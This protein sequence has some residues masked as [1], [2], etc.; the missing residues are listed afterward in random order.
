M[1]EAFFITLLPLFIAIMALVVVMGIIWFFIRVSAGRNSRSAAIMNSRRRMKSACRYVFTSLL[2]LTLACLA[3]LLGVYTSVYYFVSPSLAICG[4][5]AF[6]LGII[7]IVKT[8]GIDRGAA[9]VTLII[10]LS[11]SAILG[12]IV[13]SVGTFF[14]SAI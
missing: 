8:A 4:I 3:V 2:F 9:R 7:G 12:A 11:L 1:D 14:L 10:L 13:V 6:I 5:I